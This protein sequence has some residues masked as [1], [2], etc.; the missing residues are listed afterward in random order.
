MYVSPER[1][2]SYSVLVQPNVDEDGNLQP[3]VIDSKGRIIVDSYG[4]IWSS[5]ACPQGQNCVGQKT[6][7]AG[8]AE[9]INYVYNAFGMGNVI[10]REGTYT[11]TNYSEGNYVPITN[12]QHPI[13]LYNHVHVYGM[14]SGRTVIKSPIGGFGVQV[15]LTQIED[16]VLKGMTIDQSGGYWVFIDTQA[17]TS[18]TSIS[19]ILLEDLELLTGG[20]V[21]T[22][23]LNIGN[24]TNMVNC[25]NLKLRDIRINANNTGGNEAATLTFC[26][27]D[28]S[29]TGNEIDGLYVVN[30]SGPGFGIW[31]TFGGRLT[32]RRYNNPSVAGY[33][34]TNASYVSTL[35]VDVYDSENPAFNT[36]GQSGYVPVYIRFSNVSFSNG[37]QVPFQDA[38][39]SPILAGIEVEGYIK[40]SASF[41]VTVG[42]YNV[43]LRLIAEPNWNSNNFMQPFYGPNV[44]PDNANIEVEGLIPPPSSQANVFIIFSSPTNS[45]QANVRVRGVFPASLTTNLVQ[46]SGTSYGWPAPFEKAWAANPNLFRS[47]DV[48]I[49]DY[50]TGTIYRATD[51]NISTPSVP[52]SGTAQQNS[53][54][55]PVLVYLYGGTVTEVQITKYYG[56]TYTVFSNSSGVSMSGQ[57]FR[58][59]P[60]DSITITYS[61]APSWVWVPA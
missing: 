34:N 16:I 10:I 42:A 8:I 11:I 18:G 5:K 31:Q 58:L 15:N 9:A 55:Y 43:R 61:S 27:F 53:N 30:S 33:I 3:M 21:G 26:Y 59:D 2:N 48:E 52:S 12:S 14:G 45:A 46:V 54:P 39:A 40:K 56:T 44:L 13:P 36:G 47:L 41:S 17:Q 22:G 35:Y 50:S 19:D 6:Q 25:R 57:A 51:P 60:G 32:F 37:L 1:R 7:T 29:G 38:G 20:N 49:I 24:F 28:P 23:P 4:Y